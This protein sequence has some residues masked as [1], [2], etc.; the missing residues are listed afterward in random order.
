MDFIG[1]YFRLFPDKEGFELNVCN[2]NTDINNNKKNTNAN[3]SLNCCFM[4]S[5]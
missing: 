4:H 5:F 1:S 2:N 3:H